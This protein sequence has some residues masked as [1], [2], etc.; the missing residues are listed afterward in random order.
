MGVKEFDSG[1]NGSAGTLRLNIIFGRLLHMKKA[2]ALILAVLMV[3]SCMMFTVAA[4]QAPEQ[5]VAFLPLTD[6]DTAASPLGSWKTSDMNAAIM[7]DDTTGRKGA[8][9]ITVEGRQPAD[10]IGAFSF[11]Y[12]LTNPMDVSAMKALVFDIYV[13]DAD[14]IKGMTWDF[15]LYDAVHGAYADS[16][17]SWFK[18]Y[19]LDMLG[20]ETIVDGWNTVKVDLTKMER[21]YN[22]FADL[23]QL[24]MVRFYSNERDQVEHGVADGE[25]TLAVDNVYFTDE[26]L[27]EGAFELPMLAIGVNN[28]NSDTI[29]TPHNNNTAA[30]AWNNPKEGFRA[31]TKMWG[32]GGF[33]ADLTRY[34]ALEFDVY[35][36]NAF[37][38]KVHYTLNFGTGTDYYQANVYLYSKT[39]EE[40]AGYELSVGWNHVR[41]DLARFDAQQYENSSKRIDLTGV[42]YF[43]MQSDAS[44]AVGTVDT[45]DTLVTISLKNV[46]LTKGSDF[47][48]VSN[49][50]PIRDGE[51]YGYPSHKQAAAWPSQKLAMK[52]VD[53]DGDTELI[54]VQTTGEGTTHFVAD[55]SFAHMKTSGF[56]LNLHQYETDFSNVTGF[57]IDVYAAFGAKDT[58]KVSDLTGEIRLNNNTNF[59]WNN[60]DS[61]YSFTMDM[62]NAQPLGN[63]WYRITVPMSRVNTNTGTDASA[64]KPGGGTPDL[65]DVNI[66]RFVNMN[67][68]TYTDGFTLAVDNLRFL[69][70][71]METEEDTVGGNMLLTDFAGHG[72]ISTLNFMGNES[73]LNNSN[74]RGIF[75]GLTSSSVD[76]A[77]RVVSYEGAGMIDG[78]N[79]FSKIIRGFAN[80]SFD[81]ANDGNVI[82]N[83]PAWLANEHVTSVQVDVRVDADGMKALNGQDMD[84]SDL[85]LRLAL[86]TYYDDAWD[87]PAAVFR[88]SDGE[89]LGDGWYRVTL[90]L[91]EFYH[92]ANL[93][94]GDGYDLRYLWAARVDCNAE[95]NIGVTFAGNLNVYVDN[96]SVV[97]DPDYGNE[98]PIPENVYLALDGARLVLTEDF[99]LRFG[100]TALNVDG[101]MA[102]FDYM[103]GTTYLAGEPDRNGAYT[104][105]F[106]GILAHQLGEVVT[107]TVWGRDINGHLVSD[108][109]DYSVKQ[110]CTN[111]LAKHGDNAGLKRLLASTLVYGAEAQLYAGHD[112]D[113]PVT[114]GV[115]AV[116]EVVGTRL[117]ADYADELLLGT[118]VSGTATDDKVWTGATLVLG[119]SMKIRYYFEAAS[120]E[121][122]VVNVS[123]SGMST[124]TV[125]EFVEEDGQ[126]YFEVPVF[127]NEYASIVTVDFG[128]GYSVNYSV[129]HYLAKSCENAD[130]AKLLDAIFCYGWQARVYSGMSA[131]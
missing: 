93:L 113:H 73:W 27:N 106:D 25:L 71:E 96:I 75:A 24:T 8:F 62:A 15:M 79:Y 104:F 53:G 47:I 22:A 21:G 58:V 5:D 82:A 84:P 41:I 13:S 117:V 111:M 97:L 112:V 74:N 7:T 63:N 1:G 99:G 68:M 6:C 131:Y 120:V 130:L 78:E 51:N 35:I 69:T 116:A 60:R 102:Q 44:K 121:G 33:T 110:Y 90:P 89:A 109:V 14:A 128:T 3:T 4:E 36:D 124:G 64:T 85:A 9:A 83:H 45:S 28:Q 119:S 11:E 70:C 76:G 39:L 54:L 31:S 107:A 17:R 108:S 114:D 115:D 26:V 61:Y 103:G 86:Y 46:M 98:E 92:F 59:D 38:N 49:F 16:Y 81:S 91:T 80:T 94:Y 125:T 123:K 57:S 12:S 55:G 87:G 30:P 10:K 77:W 34:G 88:P 100:A 101:V 126:Y 18:G 37:A 48:T 42:N 20:G 2:L 66:L 32:G 105:D 65:N 127:A 122:L 129:N 52:D 50:H 43:S 29:S 72:A 23:T 40:L 56:A 67:E 95:E 118:V 19:T